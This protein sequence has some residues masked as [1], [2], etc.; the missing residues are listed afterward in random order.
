SMVRERSFRE[1]LYFRLN[2][3]TIRLPPLRE[4]PGDVRHLA[5]AFAAR[6]EGEIGRPIRLSEDALEALS[7]WS[8]PGNV[9]ELE[10]SIRRAAV[11]AQE[12][13]RAQDLAGPIGTGA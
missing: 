9:R 11:F 4:R 3:I 1:D 5:R 10:N 2:V 8:W 12:E 7:L 13:I 6:M